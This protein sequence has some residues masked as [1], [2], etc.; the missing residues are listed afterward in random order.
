MPISRITGTTLWAS[1]LRNSESPHK[2][3]A[4]VASKRMAGAV[5]CM[6]RCSSGGVCDALSGGRWSVR[7]R[8]RIKYATLDLASCGLT[9]LCVECNFIL[10]HP[11]SCGVVL[12]TFGRRC[13]D[14]IDR[15]YLTALIENRSWNTINNSF[16]V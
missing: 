7:L 6:R 13:Y 12:I 11:M 3:K 2:Q 10:T 4:P 9:L 1:I 8:S 14:V 5:G 16:S 15:I